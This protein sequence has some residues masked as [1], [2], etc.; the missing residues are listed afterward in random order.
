MRWL[1]RTNRQKNHEV[2]PYDPAKQCVAIRSSIC[3]GE[4]TLGFKDKESGKFHEYMLIRSEEELEE[5]KKT[6]G[7]QEIEIIY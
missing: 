6:Y 3:T 5:F 1:G 7:I 4:R 2:L